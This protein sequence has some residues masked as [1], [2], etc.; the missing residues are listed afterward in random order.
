[1]PKQ[2]TRAQVEASKAKAERFVRDVLE[3]G[4]RADEIADES[5]E[6]YAERRRF[7]M[8]NPGGARRSDRRSVAPSDAGR[9]AGTGG[10][11]P[12]TTTTTKRRS[13]KDKYL[14]VLDE[15]DALK[16]ENE[17]LQARLDS[18]VNVAVGDE[19]ADEFED[20]DELDDDEFEDDEEADDDA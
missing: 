19:E 3:D 17:A 13:I 10:V 9:V 7:Q 12:M 15:N 6:S 20:D 1:M 2:R 18:I 5:V 16:E 8:V 14:D 11:R 4:E